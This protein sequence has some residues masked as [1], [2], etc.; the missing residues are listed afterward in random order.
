MRKTVAAAFVLASLTF[1]AVAAAPPT[2][3]SSAEVN[4]LIGQLGDDDFQVRE[5]ATGRLLRAGEP[6]LDAL[7][8]ALASDDLEVRRRAGRIVAAIEGRLYPELYLV[9]HTALVTRICVSADGKRLLGL[10]FRSQANLARL[11]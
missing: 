4:R 10:L 11:E 5:A 9:G 6:A 3:P 2:G 1:A 7:H 8:K